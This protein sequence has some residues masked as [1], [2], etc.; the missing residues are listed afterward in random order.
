MNN[1]P[2]KLLTA[3]DVA[4]ILSINESTVYKWAG[5]RRL[6]Y[7]DLGR[8]GR[9]RCLRFRQKDLEKLIEEKLV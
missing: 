2:E 8:N 3:K 4:E 9:K 7:V 1:K 5:Q 6:R